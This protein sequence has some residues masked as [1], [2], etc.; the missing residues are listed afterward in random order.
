[1]SDANEISY[2]NAETWHPIE[3]A[4]TGRVVDGENIVGVNFASDDDELSQYVDSSHQLVMLIPIVADDPLVGQLRRQGP[5][6]L[7]MVNI[8]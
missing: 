5:D 4:V 8:N 7:L 2:D 1:M 6:Y 3:L